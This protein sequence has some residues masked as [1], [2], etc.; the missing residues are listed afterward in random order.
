MT[1]ALLV[2]PALCM[3]A[4]GQSSGP[5]AP[6]AGGP[7]F[8]DRYCV[9]CHSKRL[10]TA[11]LVLE[12]LDPAHADHDAPTWE[13]VIRKVRVGVMPPSGARQPDRPAAD[14]FVA[15]LQ[16]VLDRAAQAHPSIGH[17]PAVHRLNRTEY[18]N[19]IRDLLGIESFPKELDISVLLPPDDSGGGFDNM[20]D[21]LYVSPTL[22]ERFVGAADK[23][24][25]LA[26]GD[27]SAPS[28]VDTYRA[29]G[30]MPQDIHVE[31]LP[32]GTR[33]GM[34]IAR[35]FPLDG[36]Y[37][38]AVQVAQGGAFEPNKDAPPYRIELTIDGERVKV[39]TQ[40]A[41]GGGRRGRGAA[42][43]L[44][45][46]VAMSAGPHDVGIA[47]I[48]DAAAPVESLVV[49]YRRSLGVERAAIAALTISGP[50]KAV[51]VG[52]TPS[53]RRIFICRPRAEAD[54]LPCA[55]KIMTALARRA[56]RRP[57]TPRDVEPLLTFY[58]KGRAEAGFEFGIRRSLERLLVSPEFLFRVE[59]PP[60]AGISGPVALTD[61]E[62]ASRL[63]FFLWSSI[64]DDELLD[65]ASAGRLHTPAVFAQ[66]VHRML[67]D[68]RS[69]ALTDNFVGQWLYLRDLTGVKHPDDRLFPDFDEGLQASMRRETELFFESL[70]REHRSVLDL[71]RADYTF[72][73]ERLAQHYGI[74][75]V[76]GTQFRRVTL[77]NDSP[78]RGLLGQGS[79]LTI[80]SYA[81]RTS[82]VNRGKFIL[83]TLL[84]MPPPP[85]PANVPSLKDTDAKGTVL[86]MRARMEQHRK[87]P[88]CASCHKQM[89]P[90]GFALENFDAVG[91]WRTTGE[92]NQPIDNSGTLA[93]GAT[94]NGV[95]GLRAV[96]LRH[97]FD[98]ELVYTVV[99][100][101]MA[102]ALGR[103]LDA[104]DQPVIRA[105]M[106]DAAPKDYSFDAVLLGI[107]NSPSFRMKQAPPA[108]TVAEARR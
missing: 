87:S 60:Q 24:S 38:F 105:I 32:F 46:T 104:V 108:A 39:F 84:S 54:E 98:T 36:E 16:T 79:V 23:I 76:H 73:N 7:G 25:R 49:P 34:L 45:A 69:R 107:V 3:A 30:Q 94:F 11:D 33:G 93:N 53:R 62:L 13:K 10:H 12:G 101:L 67:A 55:T 15:D 20:A 5:P 4:P 59:A 21:A 96:L 72:L 56:Y 19:A 70:V 58:R 40:Q 37:T 99:S 51:S 66:Q 17:V 8:V 74:P 31:G 22:I 48:A 68:G 41:G 91:R 28:I 89:D 102:Y 18:S 14:A 64:P 50:S 9:T 88:A 86:S 61:L 29:S 100:K 77:P 97:P 65:V 27:V 44:Q 81:N 1:A 2:A 80:T 42:S 106:R 63:S 26:V 85:P 78:R 43:P 47:F 75:N 82:P 57:V 90:L 92:S 35:T 83:E 95:T 6:H 103:P 71:L 52:D